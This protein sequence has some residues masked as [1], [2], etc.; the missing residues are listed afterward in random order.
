MIKHNNNPSHQEVHIIF[1]IIHLKLIKILYKN[2][3]SFA[4]SLNHFLSVLVCITG[5]FSEKLGKYSY[6]VR[7][8]Y[9][10]TLIYYNYTYTI[11]L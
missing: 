7:N 9:N 6:T 11:I 5:M 10:Y 2:R 4:H 3:K 8:N 1:C